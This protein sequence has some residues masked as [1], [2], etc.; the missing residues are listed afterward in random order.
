[1]NK[2]R[3]LDINNLKILVKQENIEITNNTIRIL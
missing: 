1:M 2:R 3:L